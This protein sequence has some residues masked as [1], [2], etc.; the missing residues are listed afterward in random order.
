MV[1]KS[2]WKE[3]EGEQFYLSGEPEIPMR[4]ITNSQ[5]K[6]AETRSGHCRLQFANECKNFEIF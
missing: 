3:N 6:Q 1:S 2:M 5:R 4:G